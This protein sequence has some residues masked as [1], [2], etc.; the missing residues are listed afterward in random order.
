LE[1]KEGRAER[2]LKEEEETRGKGETGR[3]EGEK[4][5]QV[6]LRFCSVYL[7][8]VINVPKGWMVPSLYA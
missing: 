6:K 1:E 3:G 5:R 4:P 8:V 2:S 7:Q